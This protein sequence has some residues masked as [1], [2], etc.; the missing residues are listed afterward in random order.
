MVRWRWREGVLLLV[1]WAK[2]RR[3]LSE[4]EEKQGQLYMLETVRKSIS[5]LVWSAIAGRRDGRIH[6]AD[7]CFQWKRSPVNDCPSPFRPF[8]KKLISPQGL[9][10]PWIVET[11]YSAVFWQEKSAF[12]WKMCNYSHVLRPGA[13]EYAG[14]TRSTLKKVPFVTNH[15]P[16]SVVVP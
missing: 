5:Q 9:N 10:R 2:L 13:S 6:F 16:L 11:F 15:D 1:G 14:T 3:F 8:L 4:V 7:L 12:C